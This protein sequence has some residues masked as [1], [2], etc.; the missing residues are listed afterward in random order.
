MVSFQA[1]LQILNFDGTL[2]FAAFL[3]YVC[4]EF[5][6]LKQCKNRPRI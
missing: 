3:L 6:G 2:K 4:R 1:L 5:I